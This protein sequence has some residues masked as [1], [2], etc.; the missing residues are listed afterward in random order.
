M[1]PAQRGEC[2]RTS[3]THPLYNCIYCWLCHTQY[4]RCTYGL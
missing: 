1:S 2:D 3:F 4:F